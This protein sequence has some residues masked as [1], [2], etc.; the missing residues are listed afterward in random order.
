MKSNYFNAVKIVV[1][2]RVI[3][4]V[5]IIFVMFGK[6]MGQTKPQNKTKKKAE[7]QMEFVLNYELQFDSITV[8]I[9]WIRMQEGQE[10]SSLSWILKQYIQKSN[11]TLWLEIP[12]NYIPFDQNYPDGK[13]ND[14]M[15]EIRN[16]HYWGAD[17]DDEEI[18]LIPKSEIIG[19]RTPISEN[20]KKRKYIYI[21]L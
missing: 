3:I 20:T 16:S 7:K 9:P 6:A 1:V 21:Y 5:I 12:A 10:I 19:N 13:R 15:V 14:I 11:D 4:L 18:I 8:V 2:L 17:K